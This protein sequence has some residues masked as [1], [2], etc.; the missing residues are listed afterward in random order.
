M[1]QYHAANNMR[2][3]VR[4]RNTAMSCPA[5][6]TDATVGIYVLRTDAAERGD[7]TDLLAQ[8]DSF[9]CQKSHT[10]AVIAAIFQLC[11]SIQYN[12]T[13]LQR[14]YISNNTTHIKFSPLKSGQ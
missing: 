12:V 5:G 9:L 2:M 3:R 7:L 11:Q 4:V 13:C 6:M 10:G 14:P 8:I 1:K